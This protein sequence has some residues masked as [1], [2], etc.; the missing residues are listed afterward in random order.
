MECRAYR[1]KAAT[2]PAPAKTGRPVWTGAPLREVAE[3]ATE[4]AAEVAELSCERADEA[5]E[6]M[7]LL[8][9]ELDAVSE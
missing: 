6:L 1:K 3:A 5:A 7:A 4:P 2:I 8:A 9:E